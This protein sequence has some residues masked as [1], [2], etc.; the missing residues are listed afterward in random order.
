MGIFDIDEMINDPWAGLRNTDAYIDYVLVELQRLYDG[1]ALEEVSEGMFAKYIFG[2]SSD[3][4]PL[5]CFLFDGREFTYLYYG[6]QLVVWC[7]DWERSKW[8]E[9]KDGKICKKL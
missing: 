3:C 5:H 2:E 1:G 4:N 9:C 6:G 7:D 8:F